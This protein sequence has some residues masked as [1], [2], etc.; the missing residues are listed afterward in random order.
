MDT[1]FV[2]VLVV[3]GFLLGLT[4]GASAIEYDRVEKEGKIYEQK[5]K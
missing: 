2:V 5:K 3:C 1:V 4:L